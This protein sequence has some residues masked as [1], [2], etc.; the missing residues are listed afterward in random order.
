[1]RRTARALWPLLAVF[2]AS[3]PFARGL[4][5]TNVFYVRDLATFFWP[6]H[7]W[8]RHTLM[9]GSWPLW[10]P[11]AGAGQAVFP[12]ALNQLFLPPVLLLRALPAVPGFNLLVATPFPLAALGMWLFLRR[13]VSET[14]A[15]LGAIAFSA[16]GPVVSTGNFPNL[17]WSMAWIPWIVW[18]ADRDRV[19][20][21]ARSFALLTVMIAF[22]I[23][24]GEPVSMAGT[25]ALLIGYVVAC[26]EQ[27]RSVR[28]RAGVVVRVVGAISTAAMISAVQLVP[29]A[30]AARESPRG[31]MRAD[32]FWS[33]H[34]LWL[35]ESV[36]PHIFGDTFLQY[37]TQLP[38]IHPLNS[39]RDPFFYSLSVGLVTLLLSVL[40]TICGPRRW[41]FFWLTVV[42]VGLVA[43]FG[44]YT[45]VYPVL[46]RMVP[47][48]RGF[49]YPAKFLLFA[50]FGLAT[51]AATGAD[52]LR[53]RGA[54]RGFSAVPPAAVGITCGVGLA[55][56]LAL[57]TVIA[58]VL[59]APSGGTR[60]F[61]ALGARVG[62]ADPGAG[63]AY[64]FSAVPP[65]AT[66]AL[67]VLAT[68]ALIVYLGRRGGRQGRLALMLL[69]G[70]ATAELLAASAGLNPVLPASRLGPPAWIATLAADPAERFYFGGKFRGT[71]T[72]N[73]IDLRGVEW[74]T[75]QGVTVLEGRTLLG[76]NLAMTPSAW[77]VREL[78][79]LDL[80][81]LWPIAQ[82]RAVTRFERANAAERLR[83][84]AR[85]GVR[86]CLLSSP[87]YPGA[88]PLHR[89]GEEFGTMAVYECVTDARRAYVVGKASIVADVTTQ[90]KQLFEES[91]DADS[92]VMLERPAPAAAGSPGASTAP[93]ARITTDA[94]QEVAIDAAA[95]AEGGYLVL[96]DTF[97][98]AWHV[99]VDGQPAAL[100]R[101]NA[102]YRAVHIS[103][104]PHRIRFR[105]RPIVLYV[106]LI[107]SSVTALT[108]MVVAVWPRHSSR[109]RNAFDA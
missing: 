7:L 16:S 43:A 29:M 19:A 10:D 56:A 95:G 73:D 109:G 32:N 44:D 77:G 63:T 13:H 71:L 27:T 46:Q 64:L 108:L 48:L 31:L 18:A 23:L 2:T 26:R 33:V 98:P 91:F 42:A 40:G 55:A 30:L 54:S 88:V 101:A 14:S 69:F 8:I 45:P 60:A 94:D 85:G 72:E 102:L 76:V 38:W 106:W 53:E 51:L 22:Q 17:S 35:V 74:R 87:P 79:S 24:S 75:P 65:I 70:L 52:A 103:P 62:V 90:Q 83:F 105:Y 107:F 25:M 39:G 50:S 21:S 59:V 5:L 92:T 37:N 6:R 47:A 61:H 67:L 58:L 3:V 12:D 82:A 4:S 66:R 78:I 20:P 15:A 104:G 84:L 81:Q 41:R 96:K 49:R 86:Y 57:V 34:P 28:A 99:E 11:Y 89:V 36:L 93:S 80:P 97:D 68:I 100:L 9:A 1:M